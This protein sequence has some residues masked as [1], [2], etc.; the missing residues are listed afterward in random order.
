M[1]P[2]NSHPHPGERPREAERGGSSGSWAWDGD[3]D[4]VTSPEGEDALLLGGHGG[5]DPLQK[6]HTLAG[7]DGCLGDKKSLMM[8]RDRTQGTGSTR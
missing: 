1:W 3:T 5:D 2:L 8:A 7:G 6:L 4:K